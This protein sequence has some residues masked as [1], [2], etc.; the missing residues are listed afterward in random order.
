MRNKTVVYKHL[1]N[2]DKIM[3]MIKISGI[4][5]VNIGTCMLYECKKGHSDNKNLSGIKK[6]QS[7]ISVC[8][9]NANII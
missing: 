8:C 5:I 4:V 6:T 2:T 9:R 3:E 7:I 1:K